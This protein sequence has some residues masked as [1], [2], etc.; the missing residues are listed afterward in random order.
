M[1]TNEFNTHNGKYTIVSHGNGWGYEVYCNITG[2]NLWFQDDDAHQLQTETNNFEDT[3]VLSQY[4]EN[5]YN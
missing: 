1:I 5:L 2:D 4:F 3:N